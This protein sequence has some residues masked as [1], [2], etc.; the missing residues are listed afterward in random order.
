MHQENTILIRA[1]RAHIFD[2]VADLDRWPQRLPHY[3]WIRTIQHSGDARIVNMAARRGWIP[4]RWTSLFVVDRANWE[5]RFTHLKAFTR[6]MHVVWTFT[7]TA[8]GILVRIAHDL[9]LGWPLI[10][11]FVA[12]QIIGRFFIHPVASR[13][14]ADFKKRLE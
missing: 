3:R 7:P 11:R 14:L 6:G 5:I 4:I 1:D 13:T 2:T 8:D 12:K 10:G 9:D